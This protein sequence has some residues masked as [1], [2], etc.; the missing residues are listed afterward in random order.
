MKKRISNK[1]GIELTLSTII[2]A[3]LL[4]IVLIVLVAL[5]AG[6]VK[7]F[8]QTT[9]DIGGKRGTCADLAKGDN[10]RYSQCEAKDLIKCDGE[11]VVGTFDD[12]PQ[13]KVCCCQLNEQG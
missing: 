10:T 2:L 9:T 3:A 4:V 11:Q 1:K 6:R 12:V 5:F 8:G 13:G 7:W